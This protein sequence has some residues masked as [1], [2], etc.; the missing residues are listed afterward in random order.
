MEFLMTYGWA[1]LAAIIVIGVLAIYFKPSS[2]TPNSAI[3]T[4]PFYILASS[5]SATN[6]VQIDLQNNGGET[7]TVSAVN[8]SGG[9]TDS[10]TLATSAMVAGSNEVVVWNNAVS[11]GC[12]ALTAGDSFTG[13]ITVTYTRP[14]STLALTS[15]GTVSGTVAA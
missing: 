9:C 7:L 8:I 1:I 10:D 15:T 6:G 4:A 5:I 12:A 14:D 13:D 2:L 3:V 11:P